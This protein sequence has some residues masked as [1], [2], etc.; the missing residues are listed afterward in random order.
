ML[1][2]IFQ[3][4]TIY[5]RTRYISSLKSYSIKADPKDLKEETKLSLPEKLRDKLD[6]YAEVYADFL[7]KTDEDKQ[8][9]ND[10]VEE[11][12][13]VSKELKDKVYKSL[14]H[15]PAKRQVSVY[16]KVIK[17]INSNTKLYL[18]GFEKNLTSREAKYELLRIGFE[19]VDILETVL[20]LQKY[21]DVVG[22]YLPVITLEAYF[23]ADK[24]IG[25]MT[26]NL[27]S[28]CIY[29][30][31]DRIQFNQIGE[32]ESSELYENTS[33]MAKTLFLVKPI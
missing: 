18:V 6:V 4:L 22:H 17:R 30:H 33:F 16:D 2:H 19:P 28:L 12:N 25:I 32:I 8:Q 27:Y 7:R 1:S 13:V 3:K 15:E 24:K 23:D 14:A 9:W 11:T 5:F 31:A 20:F 10:V 21:K 26:D 29:S